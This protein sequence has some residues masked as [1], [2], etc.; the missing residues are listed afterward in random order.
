MKVQQIGLSSKIFRIRNIGIFEKAGLTN[1][2]TRL[3]QS[4][5][6]I[7]GHMRYRALAQIRRLSDDLQAQ[8]FAQSVADAT[9]PDRGCSLRAFV[10]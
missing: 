6:A 9:C 7:D 4:L 5:C 8:G 2:Q 1:G 10:L 3:R